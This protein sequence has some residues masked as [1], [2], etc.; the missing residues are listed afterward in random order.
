MV[1]LARLAT[2]DQSDGSARISLHEAAVRTQEAMQA[3]LDA[4]ACAQPGQKEITQAW[5][6]I[7]NAIEALDNALP[8]ANKSMKVWCFPPPFIVSILILILLHS[9]N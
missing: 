1:Y 4:L 6:Q 9:R 2:T 5:N 3:L 8:H 7:H